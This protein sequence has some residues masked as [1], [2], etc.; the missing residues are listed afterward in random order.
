MTQDEVAKH[1]GVSRSTVTQI[2]LGNRA[3]TG[4]E[5]ERLA[6]L[7]GR[8]MRDL[9]AESFREEEA[10]AALFR[11][12]PEI[13]G[14]EGVVE[15]LRECMALGRELTRLE[16]LVGID[17]DL[18]TAAAYPWAVPSNRWEAIQQ[19]ARVAEEERRRLGLGWGPAPELTELLETQGVRTGLVDLPEDVSG[20]TLSDRQVGLFVVAN[21]HHH[22]TRRRFSFAHEYAHVLLDRERFGTVSRAAD[23]DVLIEIR[24]NSF[25]ACF[26]MP[27]ESVR[28]FIAGLGKGK[29]SRV[30]ERVY[31]E[32]DA[33]P[34]EGRVPPGSQDVQLYDVVQLAHHFGVSRPAVLYRL[35]NLRLVSDAELERLKAEDDRGKGGEVARWLDLPEPDH[36]HAR[37]EFRHRFL[38]L[39]LE[40]FRRKAIT[41]AKLGELAAMVSLPTSDLARLIEDTG[42]TGADNE[43]SDMRLPEG[44]A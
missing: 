15:K 35:K 29:P 1:L 9:V 20:L 42:L 14:Q 21:R 19:G 36:T 18:S 33:L 17:K 31:D 22:V 3:L 6:Y 8:D 37:N 26:L 4:L 38:G 24:A 28:Q 2:E 23:R 25:A 7:F 34:V 13:V 44:K 16:R 5:L 10:L 27:E 43:G 41:R 39:A 32:Y 12:Q 30:H 11:A 40:A